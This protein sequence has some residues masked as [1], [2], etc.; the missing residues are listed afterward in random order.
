MPFWIGVSIG[1]RFFPAILLLSLWAVVSLM[2]PLQKVRA[3]DWL[4][5]AL[6]LISVAYL[7]LGT[8]E[9]PHVFNLLGWVIPYFLGRSTGYRVTRESLILIF[10]VVG[11]LLSLQSLIEF[12]LDWHPFSTLTLAFGPSEIWSP[13]LYRSSFARSEGA[14]GHPIALG[15]AI[16]ICI[17]FVLATRLRARARLALV[18]VMFAAV[19]VT[20]SRNA[21]I[22]ALLSVVLSFFFLRELGRPAARVAVV[23]VLLGAS[24]ALAPTYLNSIDGGTGVLE[25]SADYRLN[26]FSVI[27]NVGLFGI[28]DIYTEYA[29]GKWGWA[30]SAYE[31]DVI[32]T[33]DNTIL[34]DAL[35]FGSLHAAILLF[36]L[37]DIVRRFT[38]D[39][40]NPALLAIVAQIP[41]LLAVAMITQLPY[42]LWL[43]AG[44]GVSWA[45]QRDANKGRSHSFAEDSAPQMA[46]R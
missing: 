17:P 16:A 45:E 46:S 40:S 15:L 5:I 35:Q 25:N 14:L 10:A 23:V 41:A 11:L 34:L 26:F 44:I 1:P 18:S 32:V 4:V 7:A 9:L 29:P 38:R 13:I 28:S 39:R 21:I 27:P 42:L 30:S 36:V 19:L 43:I 31:E 6:G 33:L 22:A 24:V 3:V 12:S 2:E 8:V 20:F 37:A